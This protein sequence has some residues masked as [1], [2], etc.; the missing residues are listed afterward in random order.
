MKLEIL[1]IP[2][3]YAATK[4]GQEFVQALAINDNVDL[5]GSDSV[6]KII[7]HHWDMTYLF[8]FFGLFVPL[9][10]QIFI[11]M[12]WNSWI[13]EHRML[14]TTRK[15]YNLACI[16][17]LV[18]LSCYFVLIEL[19]QSTRDLKNYFTLGNMFDLA[20]NVFVLYNCYKMY[21]AFERKEEDQ[22]F[23]LL[24]AFGGIFLSLK[25]LT[26]LRVFEY[27]GHLIYML[28]E[29]FRELIPFMI[30]LGVS[31]L[32]FTEAFY[33]L[34]KSYINPTIEDFDFLNTFYYSL[35][36]TLGEFGI[37][38]LDVW[39]WIL[40]ILAALFN[41]IILLNLVIAII[42][43]VFETVSETK[44]QSFYKE[45]AGLIADIWTVVPVIFGDKKAKFSLLFFA[46]ENSA[47]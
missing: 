42:S 44:I 15:R 7:N 40:F 47:K 31:I 30:V 16:F 6:Q 27:T 5:F 8:V 33:S 12:Y 39:G 29:V 23:W 22:D 24:Q 41:L 2:E 13:I 45:R 10:V 38:G 36:L 20:P 34:Q 32:G 37:D 35:L 25:F 46:T 9:C 26:F 18:I 21:Y 14:D 4:E 1:D 17:S 43:Q 28:F 11:F 19:I 3:I